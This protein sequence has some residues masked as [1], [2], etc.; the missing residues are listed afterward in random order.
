MKKAV[1]IVA[2][3]GIAAAV[4]VL[5]R[6]GGS[7]PVQSDLDEQKS[8]VRMIADRAGTNRHSVAEKPDVSVGAKPKPVLAFSDDADGDD[9]RSPEE[10]ALAEKIEAALDE[11]SLPAAIECAKAALECPNADVRHAMVE[12]LG[13]F[14]AKGLPEL[15]PFLADSDA[16]VRESAMNEW[17][18]AL[19]DIDDEA[20]KISTVEMAM[21]VLGDEEALEDIS[22]EYIGVDEK[23]AVESL[24]R[25]IEGEG[26]EKGI[27]KA[28]ETYEFVTGEEYTGRADAERWIAEE[29]QP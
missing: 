11:E 17:S 23:L 15:T 16:G 27:E 24:V 25:I 4:A 2:V 18:M 13:W 14:G 3:L 7:S 19:A 10:K 26:S 21:S 20:Q 22:G 6:V 8:E 9:D 5:L 1:L 29:Y 28:K 12:T